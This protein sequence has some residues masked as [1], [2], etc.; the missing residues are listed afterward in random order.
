MAPI[1]HHFEKCGWEEVQ[2][3]FVFTGITLLFA[4]LALYG[5]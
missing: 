3:V 2:I 1:H 4:G 5:I